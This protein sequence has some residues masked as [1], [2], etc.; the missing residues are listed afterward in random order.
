LNAVLIERKIDYQVNIL[1]FLFFTSLNLFKLN[2]IVLCWKYPENN[3]CIWRSSQCKPG[4]T[5]Q[6]S[7]GDEF[8]LEKI[9]DFTNK[10]YIYD[11]RPYLNAFANRVNLFL[12]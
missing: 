1:L 12:L 2:L 10:I 9:S 11:A 3:T 6:R 7:T 4:I 5:Q 8:F